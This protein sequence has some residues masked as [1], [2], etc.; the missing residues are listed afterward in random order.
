[1]TDGLKDLAWWLRAIF[2]RALS[3]DPLLR[4]LG[5][6]DDHC[7]DGALA[8][9]GMVRADLFRPTKSL[10]QHRNRISAMLA[11]Y[12]LSPTW[13]VARH[14][15]ALKFADHD[16]AYCVSKRR[17]DGWLRGKRPNDGPRLFCPNAA[18]F[19]RWRGEAMRLSAAELG[20]DADA[21]LK[22]GVA[23]ARDMVENIRSRRHRA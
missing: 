15:P 8:A 5:R 19:E 17:C 6:A 12:D 9:R 13:L 16:C 1:M 2:S 3:A 22:N 14:W 4:P 10:A 21:I 7:V 23:I 20:A 11:A 18:T